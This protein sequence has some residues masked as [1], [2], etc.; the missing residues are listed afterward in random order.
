MN[1]KSGN[2]LTEMNDILKRWN[3]YGTQLFDTGTEEIS[4]T[5]NINVEEKEPEPLFSEVE[6]AI[7]QLKNGKSPGMDGIPAELLKNTG[8]SGMKVMHHLCVKVWQTCQWTDE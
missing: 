5:P 4:T 7:R 3:E 2:T 6:A 1:D 8:P